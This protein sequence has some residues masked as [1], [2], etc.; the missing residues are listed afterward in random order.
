MIVYSCEAVL[1]HTAYYSR[2]ATVTITS[3]RF[4][5]VDTYE[6]ANLKVIS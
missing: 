6:A 4:K 3:S 5:L 2:V 1:C